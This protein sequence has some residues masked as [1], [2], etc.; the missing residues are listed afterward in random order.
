MVKLTLDKKE[1]ECRNQPAQSLA[2][3]AMNMMAEQIR[4][5]MSEAQVRVMAEETLK[6]L[7]SEGF[8]YHNVGALVLAGRGRSKL[9][10][11][12]REYRASEEVILGENDLISL[13]FST[14]VNGCWGDYARTIYI[15]DGR[16]KLE[17]EAPVGAEFSEGYEMELRL[18]RELMEWVRPETTYEEVSEHMSRIL[19]DAGF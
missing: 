18:H 17:P 8:W 3:K 14:V 19:L 1:Q 9:S 15:E 13:D 4:P 16:A 7:G 10:V 5:G 2:E 11:S 12:G 6:E